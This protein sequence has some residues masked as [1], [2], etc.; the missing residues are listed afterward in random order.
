LAIGTNVRG[1]M[2]GEFPGLGQLDADD[3]L[4]STS[5]FRGLYCSILEQWFN[6]DAAAVIPSASSFYRPALIG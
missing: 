3:N 6:V 2:I 4:R 1:R 5:D